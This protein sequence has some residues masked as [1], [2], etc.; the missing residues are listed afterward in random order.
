MISIYIR[1]RQ[2]RAGRGRSDRTLRPRDADPIGSARNPEPIL[3]CERISR[4]RAARIIDAVIERGTGRGIIITLREIG[5]RAAAL[6]LS[7]LLAKLRSPFRIRFILHQTEIA[8]PFF[9]FF[10]PKQRR[11]VTSDL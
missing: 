4:V 5:D 11:P 1:N 7:V 6:C 10:I 8:F 9:F 2:L 3:H